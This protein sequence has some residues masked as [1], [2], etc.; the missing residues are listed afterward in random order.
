MKPS[1]RLLILPSFCVL[2][3]VGCASHE[4]DQFR[5]ELDLLKEEKRYDEA[6]QRIERHMHYRL[7]VPERPSWENPYIYLLTIGDIQLER[8]DPQKALDSYLEADRHK[9]DE[10]FVNDRLRHI[11]TWYEKQK[12][13]KKA[14]DHLQNF[15]KRD[16]LLFDFMLDR[17]GKRMIV[18]GATFET[19]NGVEPVE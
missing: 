18:E 11:A 17:I 14:L 19:E 7:S 15:R 13:L 16:P 1:C 4:A 6:I 2:L 12:E 3:L 10:G 9:V 8:G 5:E